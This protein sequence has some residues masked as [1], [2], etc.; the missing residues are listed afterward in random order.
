MCLFNII[1]FPNYHRTSLKKFQI[2]GH[3]SKI[4]EKTKFALIFCLSSI[5]YYKKK[6]LLELVIMPH[7]TKCDRGV[8]LI[9]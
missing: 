1:L 5:T 3:M 2:A 8:F 4:L 9:T 6:L 7:Q